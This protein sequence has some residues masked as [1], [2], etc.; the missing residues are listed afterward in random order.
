MPRPLDITGDKY[1]RLTALEY[2]GKFKNQR[3]WFFRCDCGSPYINSVSAVRVGNTSSCGCLHSEQ[4]AQRNRDNRTHGLSRTDEFGIWSKMIDRCEKPSCKSYPLYG[5]R[6]IKVCAEWH[7]VHN[8]IRDM[9]PR[10]SRLYS[11]DRI[12][13]N[14]DYEPSNCRWATDEQQARNTSRNRRITYAG[15]TQTLVEWSHET[16]IPHELIRARIDRCG[17]SVEEALTVPKQM[18][19]RKGVRVK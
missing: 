6:G 3:M 5:G 13:Y 19:R 15:K 18:L 10:P 12:D 14:G 1:G 9:G 17:W 2:V 11:I 7:D 16:G 8:F 4:L